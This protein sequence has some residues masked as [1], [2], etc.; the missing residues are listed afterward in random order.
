MRHQC[1][2][3]VII[4]GDKHP[5]WNDYTQYDIAIEPHSLIDYDNAL[6]PLYSEQGNASNTIYT[7]I[8]Q[9]A[10]N[11]GI[12]FPNYPIKLY[13]FSRGGTVLNQ[14][15]VEWASGNGL[16]LLKNIQK[17]CWVDS[18]NGDRPGAYLTNPEQVKNMCKSLEKYR[19]AVEIIRTPYQTNRITTESEAQTFMNLL[20]LFYPHELLQ[21]RILFQGHRPSLELH[22]E[23]L[24]HIV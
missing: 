10:T 21:E 17:I 8:Q 13:A 4:T 12:T 23:A 22:F 24:K 7:Y 16:D 6:N 19:V 14:L 15:A 5:L 18:G 11:R 2:P 1:A 3:S 9:E 20:K